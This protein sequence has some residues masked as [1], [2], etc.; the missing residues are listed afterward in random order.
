MNAVIVYRDRNYMSSDLALYFC[1]AWLQSSVCITFRVTGT[2][3]EMW[4]GNKL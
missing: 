3:K 4:L 1:V 2:K